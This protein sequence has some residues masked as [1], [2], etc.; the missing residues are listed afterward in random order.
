MD[1][2]QNLV[3]LKAYLSELA[4]GGICVAFSGG[5]DSAVILAAAVSPGTRVHAVTMHTPLHSLKEPEAAEKLATGLGAVHKTITLETLGRWLANNPPDRCYICK[6]WIFAAI[7]EYAAENGLDYV[8]DGTNADDLNEY[9][10]GLKALGELGVKSPLAELGITKDGVRRMAKAL[11]LVVADKPSS[12]CLATRFPYNTPLEPAM[13]EKADEMEAFIR[14]LGA[15]VVRARV[16]GDIVRLEVSPERFGDIIAHRDDIVS[17][18]KELGFNYV[19]LD[20]E[21]FRSGS[22]DIFKNLEN[23]A[24]IRRSV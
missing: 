19:A 22:M 20:L 17:K 14:K 12:P 4:P 2:L 16:H 21:G 6:K 11:G 3:R 24:P 1:A 10:P 7:K 9:R 18:V 5:V 8:L 13:L 23:D 15:Q